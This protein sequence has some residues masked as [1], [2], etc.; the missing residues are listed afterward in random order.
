MHVLQ[1][2]S[3]QAKYP[4]LQGLLLALGIVLTGF[5]IAGVILAAGLTAAAIFWMLAA[6][7]PHRWA[8]IGG[9]C[10]AFHPY[11]TVYWGRRYDGGIWPHLVRRCC[12]G[13]PSV[14]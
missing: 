10:V 5:P 11:I 2:P 14:F 9:L 3:Y 8:F 1:H 13:P 6:W 7:M 12:W 4:P